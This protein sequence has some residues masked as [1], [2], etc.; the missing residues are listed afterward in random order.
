MLEV[1]CLLTPTKFSTLASTWKNYNKLVLF[2]MW[3]SSEIIV[4]ADNSNVM[5]IAEEEEDV[6]L[7]TVEIREITVIRLEQFQT[8]R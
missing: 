5:K 6:I 7:A 1:K 2:S 4:G 8:S 3:T